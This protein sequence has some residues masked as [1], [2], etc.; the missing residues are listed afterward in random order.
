MTGIRLCGN[1]PDCGRPLRPG[2]NLSYGWCRTCYDRWD[3]NGRPETGPPPPQRRGMVTSE[4]RRAALRERVTYATQLFAQ[5]VSVDVIAARMGHTRA[6][7]NKYLAIARREGI[8]TQIDSAMDALY[9]GSVRPVRDELLPE[10]DVEALQAD[11]GADPFLR[12]VAQERVRDAACLAG[13]RMRK[14]S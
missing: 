4:L 11:P 3:A 8:M 14:A 6:T 2:E 12:A 7:I 5:G 13:V 10:L 1:I 9:S